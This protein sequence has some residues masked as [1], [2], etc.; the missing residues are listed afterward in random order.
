[1]SMLNA[2]CQAAIL[3]GIKPGDEQRI[4]GRIRHLVTHNGPEFAIGTLKVLKEHTVN[5]LDGVTHHKH[6]DGNISLAWDTKRDRPKGP[7]GLIYHQFPE[8]RRRLRVIG[9]LINA[10]ELDELTTKQVDKFKSGLLSNGK[11]PPDRRYYVIPDRVLMSIENQLRRKW[12]AKRQFSGVEL[13]ASAIPIGTYNEN[14][15]K[16]K[17]VLARRDD[18]DSRSENSQEEISRAIAELDKAA[19]NQ[20]YTAPKSSRAYW[21]KMSDLCGREDLRISPKIH[22]TPVLYRDYQRIPEKDNWP[23]DLAPYLGVVNFLQKPGGKLRSVVNVNRFVNSSLTPF[24]DSLQ[25]TFYSARAICVLN[26]AEGLTWCQKKLK[27]G[28]TLTSLDLTQAT[29]LLDFRALTRELSRLGDKTPMLKESVEYFTHLA[30]LPLY[31]PDLDGAISFRTGQ[32]L[33]MAGSFQILTVMNYLTGYQA[34]KEAG[35]D[36]RDSFRVCGDDF[37]CDSRMADAYNRRIAAVSGKTNLEKSLTSNRYAEFLSQLI[38]RDSVVP[39]KPYYRP[40]KSSWLVNA[41]KSTVDRVNHVYRLSKSD[42]EV[43]DLL[44]ATSDYRYGNLSSVRG[45]YRLPSWE[46][47]FVS[48]YLEL[49]SEFSKGGLS[50]PTLVSRE[51]LEFAHRQHDVFSSEGRE[52]DRRIYTRSPEGERVDVGIARGHVHLDEG[53]FSVAIDR[54]DHHTGGRIDKTSDSGSDMIQEAR[55]TAMELRKALDALKNHTPTGEMT[56][57]G[58]GMSL[59]V[60]D[61]AVVAM[62]SADRCEEPQISPNEDCDL[63]TKEGAEDLAQAISELTELVKDGQQSSL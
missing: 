34:A 31:V 41:E 9:A 47:S 35:L 5:N 19:I 12:N 13:T 46:R 50:Q 52:T 37:V 1:M 11:V 2:L 15:S 38:T 4:E 45:S 14:I 43:L 24:A 29:D 17:R 61:I 36:P 26:Q 53:E 33:G 49:R 10:I 32:P 18:P 57:I 39:M 20:F 30:E 56:S 8:P 63:L 44:A 51:S 7:L 3:E 6:V 16:Y 40:G 42:R 58:H 23:E 62:L 55:R 60:E 22:M 48:K 21:N 28:V 54:Y 27:E 25:D 59:P